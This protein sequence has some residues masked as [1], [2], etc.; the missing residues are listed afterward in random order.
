VNR[1]IRFPPPP[2]CLQKQ[3]RFATIL[4]DAS[5]DDERQQLPSSQCIR[6]EVARRQLVKKRAKLPFDSRRL[7]HPSQISAIY[8]RNLHVSPHKHHFYAAVGSTPSSLRADDARLRSSHVGTAALGKRLRGHI[9][10]LDPELP[11]FRLRTVHEQTQASMA[12]LELAARM[13]FIF[14]VAQM[15]LASL[16]L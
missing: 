9:G 15:G 16:G 10:A 1:T 13:L 14:G 11:I 4:V 7:H 8:G 5:G 2:Q 3:G 6:P 12:F